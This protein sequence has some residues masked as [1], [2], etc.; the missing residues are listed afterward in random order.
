MSERSYHGS[1]S[2]SEGCYRGVVGESELVAMEK[3]VWLPGESLQVLTTRTG[4]ETEMYK[5][6]TFDFGSLTKLNKQTKHFKWLYNFI[7]FTRHYRKYKK[8]CTIN[9]YYK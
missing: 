5:P 8:I 4:T 3:T 1:T 9:S 2:R 7:K 6:A